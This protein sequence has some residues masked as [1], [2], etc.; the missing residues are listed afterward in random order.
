VCFH[1]NSD[2]FHYGSLT[3]KIPDSISSCKKLF[4]FAIYDNLMTGNLT[5][6]ICKVKALEMLWLGKNQLTGSIPSCIGEELMKLELLDVSDNLMIGEVPENLGNIT[7]LKELYLNWEPKEGHNNKF[8]GSVPA[9]FSNLKL[10]LWL[11]LNVETLEGPLPDLSSLVNLYGCSFVPSGLCLSKVFSI[12]EETALCDFGELPECGNQG[13]QDIAILTIS[14]AS[15]AAVSAEGGVIGLV[16]DA[17]RKGI[18]GS[19]VFITTISITGALL[20]F[21]A[22]GTAV[23]CI[24]KRRKQAKK[25][26]GPG[27]SF[28]T[29]EAVSDMEMDISSSKCPISFSNSAVGDKPGDSLGK[30]LV[31]GPKISVGGFGEVYRGKYDGMTPTSTYT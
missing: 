20:I 23:F 2:C 10:M 4:F 30:K 8:T 27:S 1:L 29:S 22:I 19:T 15:E 14:S 5:E 31:W 16:V 7:G 18:P 17:S 25:W 21:A 9:S 12:Q 6:E 26:K 24:R 3:G 13:R 11:Y 28:T